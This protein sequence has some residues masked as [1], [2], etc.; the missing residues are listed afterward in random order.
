MKTLL[1]MRHAKS[2]WEYEVNDTDRILSQKGIEDAYAAS[3]YLINRIAKPDVVFSSPA[4]RALH[5]CIIFM[6]TLK[7]PFHKLQVV[8]DLYDFRGDQVM[9]FLRS[10]KQTYQHIALFGHNYA[11]TSLCNL[12]GDKPLEHLPTSGAALIQFQVTEWA[13]IGEGHTALTV[14]PKE[15]P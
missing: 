1:L 9:M 2:L 14:F 3:R 8:E 5:T 4:N 12:L 10:I 7:L 13:S 15:L 11:L 6:K